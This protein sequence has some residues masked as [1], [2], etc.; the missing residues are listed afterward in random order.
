MSKELGHGFSK[1]YLK[2]K[3]H[4]ERWQ[5]QYLLWGGIQV[6]GTLNKSL[7]L[8]RMTTIKKIRKY[9]VQKKIW[10][11]LELLCSVGRTVK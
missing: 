8:H 10:K 4:T 7:T 9:K 5:Y 3:K 2:A 6:K 11:Q 1:R